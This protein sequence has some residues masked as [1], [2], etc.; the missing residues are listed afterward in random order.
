M[1]NKR[2]G[3]FAICVSLFL[4]SMFYRVSSAI[5]APDLSRDLHLNPEQLGLLGGV[6]FYAFALVQLPLGLLLDRAGARLTMLVLNVIGIAGTIIFAHADDLTSAVIGRGLMG[7]G[8][9]GNLMG[10]LKLFTHWFDLGKFATL[11]GLLL[12]FGT[13][14]SIA[15]T[16]PLA[17]LVQA[18]GWRGS[19]ACL[20]GLHVLLSACLLIFAHDAPE[21]KDA[22]QD[23]PAGRSVFPSPLDAIKTLFS[24]WNYW[25]ISLSIFARYGSFV[26]IQALWAGPFLMEYLGLPPVRAGNILLMLSFGYVFGGPTGGILSDRILK[27]RK[28]AIIMGVGVSIIAVYVLASWKSGSPLPLLAGIFFVTGFFSSFNLIS[29]AHIRELMPGEMSGTAMAGVNFFTMIGGGLF[30]HGLGGVIKHMAPQLPGAGDAYRMAFM[31]CFGALVV[32]LALYLTTRDSI[33]P[34]KTIP[35]R[36]TA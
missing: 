15:A 14:G 17:L 27:S 19:F 1:S 28:R 6:F 31:I 26:S 36:S 33:V 8:M 2:W 4:M 30:I 11:S 3:I 5:I 25:A 20:A 9:A 32:A 22:K 12:S 18:L 35:A 24:S 10:P 13:L 29:Y 23:M 16:S 34:G 7:L 21:N